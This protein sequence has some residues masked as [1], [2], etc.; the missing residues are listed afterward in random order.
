VRLLVLERVW[1]HYPRGRHGLPACVALRDVSLDIEPG[2]LVAVWG[3][4]R[5][6]RTTLIEVA[7]G[8]EPPTEGGVRFGG[9][10]LARRP[11]LGVPGGIAVCGTRFERVLGDSVLEQVAVPLLDGSEPVV[12][13]QARAHRALRRVSADRCAELQPDDLDHDETIRVALAR[14]LVTRPALMLVDEPTR[15]VPPATQRDEVLRLLRSIAHDD[16][17]AVLM[18]VDEATDLAGAD[19]AMSL[20]TGEVRGETTTATGTVVALRR[21]R[22]S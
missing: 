8:I 1:K 5:S 16:G 19:R 20:D 2:E 11:M 17:V 14:A 10:D 7:A 9:V 12:A 3:R 6:G 4:R 18:T 21:V 15:G 22:R 13:A